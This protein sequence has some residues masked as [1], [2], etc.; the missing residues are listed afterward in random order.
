[1]SLS[2]FR[3]VAVLQGIGEAYLEGKHTNEALNVLLKANGLDGQDATTLVLLGDAYLQQNN[4][5]LA[6]TSYEKAT[7]LNPKSA[8]PHYKTGLVYIRSKNFAA[9]QA[10]LVNKK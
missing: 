3:N 4:G 9:A 2:K 5:G 10:A 1:M 6:V 8:Q 7:A